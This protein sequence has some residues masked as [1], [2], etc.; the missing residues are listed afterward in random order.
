MDI[1]LKWTHEIHCD[2]V[3]W[4]VREKRPIE[5]VAGT[6][7]TPSH[8]TVWTRLDEGDKISLHGGPEVS[9]ILEENKSPINT[10]MV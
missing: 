2:S 10:K 8:L 9:C 3:E 7:D 1:R 6:R 4:I 5:D